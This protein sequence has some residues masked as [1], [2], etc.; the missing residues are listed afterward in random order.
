MDFPTTVPNVV[1]S[2]WEIAHVPDASTTANLAVNE[3]ILDY[4]QMAH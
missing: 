4:V 2:D 3:Y 1:L